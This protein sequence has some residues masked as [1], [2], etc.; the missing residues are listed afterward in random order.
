MDILGKEALALWGAGL[1]TLLAVM[2][3]WEV[4]AQR[5]R[6][7]VSYSFDGRPEV[8]NDVIIR[9][10]SSTPITITYWELLF[11]EHKGIKWVP[12]R[13]EDPQ[14]D[15][16]DI[17]VKAHSSTRINFSEIN[18]F[19]WGYKSLGGKRLYLKLHLAGKRKPIKRLVYKG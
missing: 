17:F 18:Y 11:C 10:L 16:S 2:K 15:V 7:E 3:L 4:W 19:D 13:R 1:S 5:R 12:Y 6:I 9:N 14:D 8:G